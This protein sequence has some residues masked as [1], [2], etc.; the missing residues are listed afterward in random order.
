MRVW[1]AAALSVAM[2]AG[3][4]GD[5]EPMIKEGTDA[6]DESP[7][8]GNVTPAVEALSLGFGDNATVGLLWN[9][10]IDWS[11]DGGENVTYTY[12]VR[13]ETG[14]GPWMTGNGT[15]LPATLQINFTEA[16]NHTVAVTADGQTINGTIQVLAGA[17]EAVV[18]PCADFAPQEA[19]TASGMV[20]APTD[21]ALHEF[22]L[23]PCHT[24]LLA[25]VD[26]LVGG[27]LDYALYDP[28]G[29]EVDSAA[30]FTAE[31]VASESD[32]EASDADGLMPGVW[33]VEIVNF[34]SVAT[35]YD[36]TVTFA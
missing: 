19:F 29:R 11:A 22:E 35:S 3:C 6:H 21:V 2:L 14:P 30:A 28:T 34:A 8:D 18:D 17:V 5:E 33:T 10:T 20:L 7:A 12:E 16:G 24:S 1:V 23:A 4:V 25:Q 26:V 32:L 27:D 13:N 36:L 31:G 15:G 9:L